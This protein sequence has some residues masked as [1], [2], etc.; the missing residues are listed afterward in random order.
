MN[1][2]RFRPTGKTIFYKGCKS[3]NKKMM[4]MNN[5]FYRCDKCN[6]ETSEFAYRLILSFAVADHTRQVWVQAFHDECMKLLGPDTKLDE[7]YGLFE[8]NSS[9]FEDRIKAC[10]FSAYVFKLR[11][12]MEHYN[13]EGRVRTSVGGLHPVN[14]AEYGNELLRKI[15]DD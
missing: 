15:R 4:D 13:D 8:S 2:D 11:A 12:K 1:N 6:Q 10:V 5:G 14:Y 3:C 7:L 9:E